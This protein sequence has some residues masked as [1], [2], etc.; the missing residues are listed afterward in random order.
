MKKIV[1]FP[2]EKKVFSGIKPGE[3][4]VFLFSKSLRVICL[5]NY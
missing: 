2:E 3:I 1:V 5:P 4:K